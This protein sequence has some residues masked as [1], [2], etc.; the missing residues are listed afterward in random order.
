MNKKLSK[1][2]D[3]NLTDAFERSMHWYRNMSFLDRTT[4]RNINPNLKISKTSTINRK[5]LNSRKRRENKIHRTPQTEEDKT[6][7][8]NYTGQ[9][10]LPINKLRMRK[11]N[12]MNHFLFTLISSNLID[13]FFL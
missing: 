13:D 9:V 4:N 2:V 3:K 6:K 1:P 12:R 8:I 5:S 10:I 11:W 7:L